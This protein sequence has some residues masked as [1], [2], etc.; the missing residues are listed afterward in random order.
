MARVVG[1]AVVENTTAKDVADLY[2]ICMEDGR[3]SPE[4]DRLLRAAMD[5]NCDAAQVTEE[6]L[7]TAELVFTSGLQ[8]RRAKRAAREWFAT[9]PVDAA[10]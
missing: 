1:V 10:A 9:H 6:A 2:E 4:E 3:I 5:R 7:H 8:S